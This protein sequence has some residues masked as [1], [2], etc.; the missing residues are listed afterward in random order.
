MKC[1]EFR[2]NV[3]GLARGTLLDART[4]DAAAAHEEACE[5]CAAR[6]ADERALTAGFPGRACVLRYACHV[7]PPAPTAA[8]S[9][10]QCAS[11]P[12]SPPRSPPFPMPTLVTKNVIAAGVGLL[13]GGGVTPC[14]LN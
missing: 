1:Q 11:G 14:V 8:A 4:R 7:L 5:A 9:C 3:D 2:S 12:A 10:W 6:L 13:P